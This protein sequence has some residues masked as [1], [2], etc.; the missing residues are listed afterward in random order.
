MEDCC[1]VLVGKVTV[2]GGRLIDTKF[3]KN[4]FRKY[5]I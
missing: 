2:D 5:E 4:D 1:I 3:P